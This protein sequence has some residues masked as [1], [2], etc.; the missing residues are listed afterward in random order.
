[1]KQRAQPCSRER[2]IFLDT[3]TTGM[4]GGTGM[5]PFLVG[6]GYFEGDDFRVDQFFIRDFDEE[7]SM[8]AALCELLERFDLVVTYNGTTFDIPLL[9]TR[10]TLARLD[11]PFQSRG[12]FDLLN[13]A[14]RLW[15][16]GHG[17]C[18]LVALERSVMSFLRGPDVPGSMIPRVYFD[19]LQ[20]RPSPALPVVFT[21]NVYDIVS[22]AALTVLACDRVVAEPAAL[23]DPLDIYSLACIIENTEDWRR[24]LDFYERAIDGGLPEPSRSKALEN[25]SVLCRR[26]GQHDRAFQICLELIENP[27]FSMTA[28]EGAAIYHERIAENCEAALEVV[29][30]GLLRLENGTTANRPKTLLRKRWE[31]LQQKVIGFPSSATV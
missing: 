26:A 10:L 18:R 8:L 13:T 23:D 20:H 31:R 21:H 24:G 2:V 30:A 19:F 7:S 28:Y 3:E 6:V 14:R 29:E 4:Q 16:N 22:L 15:R 17:S 27:V 5:C 25:L 1:M 11:N 12:H 9:E